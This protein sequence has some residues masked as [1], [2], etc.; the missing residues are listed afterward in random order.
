M[1]EQQQLQLLQTQQ[2]HQIQQLQIQ[3]QQQL[4]Q[5]QNLYQKQLQ[6]QDLCL[7]NNN[8]YNEI[9]N[10]FPNYEQNI[11]NYPKVLNNFIDH[12]NNEI[13]IKEKAIDHH[14]LELK[15]NY[16]KTCKCYN[17]LYFCYTCC[18]E[19]RFRISGC[20]PCCYHI[21]KPEHENSKELIKN[22]LN[23]IA[24]KKSE[25]NKI[26]DIRNKYI[27]GNN[28]SNLNCSCISGKTAWLLLFSCFHFYAMAEINGILFSIFGE[29]KRTIHFY[30]YGILEESIIKLFM[31]FIYYQH[32]MIL[33]KLI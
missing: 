7:D 6:E 27:N 24:K 13:I 4:Q 3:H 12:T 33:L 14:I 22:S 26:K 20:C 25:F 15:R 23:F 1:A 31:I 30:I 10:V 5:L 2:Q 19:E 9:L 11:T 8:D 28:N 32:L 16:F 29:I 21:I 18:A 17:H